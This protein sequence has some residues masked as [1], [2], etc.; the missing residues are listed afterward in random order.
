MISYQLRHPL[1]KYSPPQYEELKKAQAI[2][3]LGGGR[4]YF[5]PEF[6]DNGAP[7]NRTLRRISYAAYLYRKTRLPILVTGGHPHEEKISEAKL[8]KN[9]FSEVFDI[10]VRW[11]E[12]KSR[13][14]HENALYSARLL[15]KD[16]IKIILLVTQAWHLSRAVPEFSKHGLKVIP[17]PT[18]FAGKPGNGIMNWIPRSYYLEQSTF[19]LHEWMGKLFYSMFY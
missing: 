17:A 8:M 11:S 9:M 7:N 14:T 10:N 16:R 5:S 18:D 4:D 1:E 19:A 2:V 3:V 6:G 13:N 15:K 12:E